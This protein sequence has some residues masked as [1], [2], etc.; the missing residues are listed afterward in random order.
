M[1]RI[2]T[3]RHD[4]LVETVALSL[5]ASVQD[6]F[7]ADVITGLSKPQKS[8]PCKY[9][10]DERGS[11]LFDAICRTPEYYPTRTELAL[12]ERHAPDIA[13]LCGSDVDLIEYGSGAQTKVRILLDAM[14]RPASYTP[15]DICVRSLMAESDILSGDYSGLAV[16]PLYADFTQPLILPQSDAL[17][18]RVGF[19]PG[20]TIGN[21]TPEDAGAFLQR[22]AS[23][24]GKNGLLIVGVDLRKNKRL[25]D[26]AY[27]DAAGLTAAFNINLLRR[28]NRELHGNFDLSAFSHGA[29]YNLVRGRVE[30]HIYSL[31]FQ[32]VRVDGHLVSFSPGESIHTENS[33][34]YAVGEFQ[35]L[36]A[37][38]GYTP[39]RCWIDDAQL[40]SLHCLQVSNTH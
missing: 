25:L 8:V 5:A 15:I 29:H 24:L 4:P 37:S 6:S 34:K 30:M 21:F 20:S 31:A 9:F 1:N 7:R 13:A 35:A 38:H 32:T 14:D 2:S 19:F 3:P 17:G 40:F 36:A 33:Y 10:Y 22:T 11:Q 28:I 27:N 26:D 23:T 39:L 18:R 16:T 12:L